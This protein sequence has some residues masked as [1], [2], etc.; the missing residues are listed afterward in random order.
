MDV[1][2]S[3]AL[4]NFCHCGKVDEGESGIQCL[5]TERTFRRTRH[6]DIGKWS[7]GQQFA[8]LEQE[9]RNLEPQR[10]E[11]TL[12]S[13]AIFGSL[14]CL[15]RDVITARCIDCH[16]F[17]EKRTTGFA[18]VFVASPPLPSNGNMLALALPKATCRTH[19]CQYRR[20]RCA[21]NAD[22]VN[23]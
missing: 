12:T 22:Q 19:K 6:S 18:Y 3:K 14:M 20:Y 21:Q 17:G 13:S 9:C 16:M 15:I 4:F 7:S 1:W 8:V 11:T 2:K 10:P 5:S 23:S